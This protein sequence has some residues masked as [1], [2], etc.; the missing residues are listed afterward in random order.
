MNT[1]IFEK[2]KKLKA[3]DPSQSFKVPEGYFESF[4]ANLMSRIEAEGIKAE[5]DAEV[6]SA[7]KR[8][9]MDVLRPYLYAAAMFVGIAL[10][11]NLIPLVQKS[12]DTAAPTTAK[13]NA[14]YQP[15]ENDE[16]FSDEEYLEFLWEETADDYMASSVADDY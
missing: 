7:K 16:Q 14:I 13:S 11:V 6:V 15:I 3:E 9:V 5:E 10:M 12:N 1:P 8:S 4:H 2:D